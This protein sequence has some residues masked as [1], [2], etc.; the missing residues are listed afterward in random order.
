MRSSKVILVAAFLSL[1]SVA[2]TAGDD[3]TL[4]EVIRLSNENVERWR[5]S[6]EPVS[7][8]NQGAQREQRGPKRPTAKRATSPRDELMRDSAMP[9]EDPEETTY[10]FASMSLPSGAVSGLLESLGKNEVVVFRGPLPNEN[11]VDLFRRLSE[12]LGSTGD[13]KKTKK[14]PVRLP[15]R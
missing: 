9:E 1:F 4:N 13:A 10:Y 15:S 3:D 7:H 11:L 6:Q 12:M 2:A 14:S 8:A 5:Q